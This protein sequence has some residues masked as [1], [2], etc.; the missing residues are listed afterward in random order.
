MAK[1]LETIKLI[2]SL[3]KAAKKTDA[4]LWDDLAYR[5]TRPTR[6]KVI[7][8]LDK[9]SKLAAKNKGKIILVPG[10]ILSEGELKEKVTVI[11]VSA[12][13]KAKQKINAKGEFIALKDFVAG[14]EKA[15]VS[16]I[17]IVK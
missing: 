6:N 1:K 14:A 11:A 5:L 12:S 3:N 10:K 8:N 4:N 2:T 15:K 17:I 13:E 16:D 7:V 9:V